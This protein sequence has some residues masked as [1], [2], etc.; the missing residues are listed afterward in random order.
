MSLSVNGDSLSVAQLGPDFLLLGAVAVPA[1]V[2]P[3][4]A[5]V[6][7][8]VDNVERQCPGLDQAV[9]LSQWRLPASSTGIDRQVICAAH[10]V[11]P[12]SGENSGRAHIARYVKAFRSEY[13]LG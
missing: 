6:K 3:C 1:V 8:R 2:G 4:D 9:V 13:S 12:I 10:A 11:R 5:V 7:L